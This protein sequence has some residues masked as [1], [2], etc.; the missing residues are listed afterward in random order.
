MH[1]E[2]GHEMF[3]RIRDRVHSSVIQAPGGFLR[4]E[5]VVEADT[6]FLAYL[7]AVKETESELSAEPEASGTCGSGELILVVH[8][9]PLIG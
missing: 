5:S 8:D 7:P 1:S 6:V 9:D 4:C 2:L 3:A